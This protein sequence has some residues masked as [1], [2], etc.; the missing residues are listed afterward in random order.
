MESL[1]YNISYKKKDYVSFDNY[2]I[3]GDSSSAN[4]RGE[5][6][7]FENCKLRNYC[8]HNKCLIFRIAFLI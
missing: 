5:I 3:N 2:V 1:S 6:S 8:N 4:I 7:N